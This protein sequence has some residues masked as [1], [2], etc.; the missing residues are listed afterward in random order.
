MEVEINAPLT[1]SAFEPTIVRLIS[2]GGVGICPTD[3][4]YG[5]VAAAA[6]ETAIRKLYLIKSRERSPGTII[7]ASVEQLVD[8]G[9]S[10]DDLARVAHYWPNPLSVV[11]PAANISPYLKSSLIDLPVRIPN[12]PE[13]ISLLRQTGPLMTTSANHPG[14]PTSTNID[15]ARRYFGDSVDYYV[16]MGE[17]G[18]RPPSTIIGF[19]AKG[20]LVVHRQG[21]FTL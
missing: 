6:D 14:E 7:A 16:D 1:T 11:L 10:L 12:H 21:A 13:L 20:A 19:D 2:N 9:F 4:V 8:L 15:Q 17:L 18:E 3:T 5:L